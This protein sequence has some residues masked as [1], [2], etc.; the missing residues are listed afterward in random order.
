MRAVVISDVHGEYDK[1]IA[2]LDAVQFDK[3]K[4]MLISNGDLIDRG[5]KVMECI[6]YVLS[7][8]HH[9]IILGNHEYMFLE[10]LLEPTKSFTMND[11]WNGE[12]ATLKSIFNIKVSRTENKLGFGQLYWGAPTKEGGGWEWMEMIDRNTTLATIYK[13]ADR[14]A[15][16]RLQDFFSYIRE[17]YK[18]IKLY[19]LTA[20]KEYFITHGW[21]SIN[22]N[23]KLDEF[24]MSENEIVASWVLTSDCM[25]TFFMEELDKEDKIKKPLITSSANNATIVVGHEWAFRL[26][27]I[28]YLIKEGRT[29]TNDKDYWSALRGATSFNNFDLFSFEVNCIDSNNHPSHNRIVMIDGCANAELGKVNAF[30]IDD[31]DCLEGG[32]SVIA[33]NL[34]TELKYS[35]YAAL[36]KLVK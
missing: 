36:R 1:M 30:C 34:D 26:R 5:P 13:H 29:F 12:G 35:G 9:F 17:G 25:R 33:Q 19:N 6:R 4:D 8:P 15:F 24:T 31:I 27:Y 32:A 28:N 3:E 16:N 18:F 10:T 2:A 21:P 11:Y 22:I 7:C 14:K 20:G 23:D